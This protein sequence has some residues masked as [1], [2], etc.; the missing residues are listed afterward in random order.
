MFSLVFL[1][2]FFV[3]VPDP[4]VLAKYHIP[5]SA[6][7]LLNMTA[8]LPLLAIWFAG[9]YGFIKLNQYVHRIKQSPDG[10]AFKFLAAG[11][12]TLVIGLA[13]SFIISRWLGN[14]IN[15][16]MVDRPLP[17]IINTHF[18]VL[19]PLISFVLILIGARMLVRT[20]K[21]KIPLRHRISVATGV[22]VISIVYIA[23]TFMDPTREATYHIPDWL[24]VTTIVLPYIA[25]LACGSYATLLI[26][27]YYRRV[28]G[29]LYRQALKKLNRGF[30]V[31]ILALSFI[32][33]IIAA[34]SF[35]S[36]WGFGSLL[37][38]I[39]ILL[40]VMA[41]GFIGI[42]RGAKRLAKLEDVT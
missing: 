37:A 7:L 32:Q 22:T 23:L 17:T 38:L 18:N 1:L 24:T 9:F 14:A 28:G 2:S 36:G 10:E 11:L 19:Y 6:V 27:A 40:I 25:L 31:V 41:I 34:N 21:I 16:H 30:I 12:T 35:L 39:Y 26:S 5:L 15:A 13:T 33:F 8:A 29:K 4:A 3:E 20:V 42:A